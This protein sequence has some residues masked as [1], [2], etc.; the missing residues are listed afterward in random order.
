ME[1]ARGKKINKVIHLLHADDV[2]R[3][4]VLRRRPWLH[5]VYKINI[6]KLESFVLCSNPFYFACHFLGDEQQFDTVHPRLDGRAAS[7][8]DSNPCV[9]VEKVVF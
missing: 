6:S 3:S 5:F 1:E 4:L 8:S 9:K 7:G 2:A